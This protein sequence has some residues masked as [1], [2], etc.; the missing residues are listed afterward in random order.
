[1]Q[2]D[3]QWHLERDLYVKLPEAAVGIRGS[4]NSS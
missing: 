2:V 4:R 1:M 3:W